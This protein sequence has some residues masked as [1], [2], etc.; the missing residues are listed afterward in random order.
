MWPGNRIDKSQPIFILQDKAKPHISI[1]DPD[2]VANASSGQCD[3]HMMCQ[4]PN[5][6]DMN[7]L[8]L[9]YFR[10]IQ[11]AYYEKS[12]SNIDE[13]IK[14][15]EVTF[16]EMPKE[17]LNKVFLSLQA[18]MVEKLKVNGGNSSKQPH[19]AKDRLF[20]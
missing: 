2:F 19:M 1:N 17:T 14:F 3:I 4:P 12:P 15:V 16:E 9:G 11:S 8:D 13:L 18:C 20:N 10:A 7:S 5:S 6:L